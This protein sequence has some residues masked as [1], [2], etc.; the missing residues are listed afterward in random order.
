[1]ASPFF[2]DMSLVTSTKSSI[3]QVLS[4]TLLNWLMKLIMLNLFEDVQGTW[5]EG[6]GREMEFTELLQCTKQLLGSV[7]IHGH[8]LPIF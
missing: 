2:R 7:Y 4:K 5:Q 1:M 6:R 8:S 3:Y